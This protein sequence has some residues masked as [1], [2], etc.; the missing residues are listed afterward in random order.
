[1]SGS[2]PASTGP[3]GP[4]FEGQVGAHYL[5]TLL[6]GGEP[7]GL[8]GTQ[9]ERVAFQRA[10]GGFPLDDVI[11]HVPH[12]GSLQI[13]VK[14]S[15]AFSA[16]DAVFKRVVGQIVKAVAEPDFWNGRNELAIATSRS[17]RKIDGPYQDVLRWARQLGSATTFFDRLDR[18][19][20]ASDDM[21]SFVN[22]F[23][24]HLR[25]AGAAHNDETVWKILQRL[26]ILVF[27]YTTPGSVSE[28][29]SRERAARVLPTRK[30]SEA[31]KLWATLVDIALAAA[32]DGGDL[33]YATLVSQLHD[34]S[35]HLG[36]PPRFAHA[37][38]KIA[39]DAALAL[40]DMQNRVSGMTLARTERVTAVNA[41][42]DSGRYVEIRGDAGVGKSGVLR[43]FAEL[44]QA[45][46]RILV[47]SPGRTPRSGW[48]TLRA[49]LDFEGTAR[50]LLIDLTT[51]GGAV[52]IIDNLDSF[53]GGQRLTVNDLVRQAAEVPGLSVLVTARRNFGVA[54][55]TWLDSDAIRALHPSPVV[56]IDELSL[57]EVGEL[58]AAEPR[59]ATLL[60]D[61]HP[62]RDVVRN[63]YRLGRLA[64]S[65]LSDPTPTTELHLA[66][67]WWNSAD[68]TR[69]PLHRDRARVLRH[70]ARLALDGSFTYDVTDQPSAAVTALVASETLRDLGNDRVT[71]Q[72]DVLRQWAI[73]N[74]LNVDITS[75]AGLPLARP[76]PE[77]VAQ[78]VELAARFL[79]ER[80]KDDAGWLKLL[81]QMS[82][83]DIHQSWRRAVLLALVH[84]DVA[85]R[86]LDQECGR[87]LENDAALLRELVLTVMA[88]DVEPA[89]QLLIAMGVDPAQVPANF[90]VPTAA[91]WSHLVRLLL[92]LGAAVPAK[93][94]SEIVS[95]YSNFMLGTFGRTPITG[96]LLAWIYAWLVELENIRYDS[97]NSKTYVGKVSHLDVDGL[98]D[99]LRTSFCLFSNRV[100]DLA[101]TYL[102]RIRALD[103]DH[104]ATSA[105]MKFR[106]TLAQAAPRELG[107]LTAKKLIA[108]R[109]KRGRRRDR[110]FWGP[111]EH[112]DSEFLPPSPA[113]GP[114]FE[115]LTADPEQG[116]EL[117]RTL[118]AHAINYYTDG[119]EAG[120]D[121]FRLEFDG[122]EQFFPWT[123]TYVW[124]RGNNNFYAMSSGLM[125]LEAWAHRRIEAGH[126]ISAVLS[127]VLGPPGGCAAF[128]LVAV[129]I[130]MSR[131][132]ER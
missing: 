8:P 78:G 60:R 80:Q 69:D 13:Q 109:P 15:I 85:D 111:F 89:S 107:A 32:A 28:E 101:A 47:L 26:L 64:L 14:R 105:V 121:G 21:R 125:A 130:V 30:A 98:L 128:L 42:L 36:G 113:Q 118:V 73:G 92:R 58:S 57:T 53:D 19:G 1:M 77:I 2:S 11:V 103:Y 24:Q 55:P 27:D 106:G 79:L 131:V 52:L 88:I 120:A 99:R 3:A 20:I 46:G 82:G 123:Q 18:P 110:D 67:Q 96:N 132:I 34:R 86:L 66:E 9:I 39:E 56:I 108:R 81:A 33:D 35:F 23:R 44:F 100:P 129:D 61:T 5:L 71:F 40:A 59:L 102:K 51:D 70:L 41:A 124:A 25:D 90:F 65:N 97:G 119:K 115:L 104:G 7:R 83:A 6:A 122:E 62:A 112:L 22:T 126:D 4:W 84:S 91:S 50:D 38:A 68:G 72:H 45:E 127:D 75:L 93:A 117:I 87:L 48:P 74:F 17:S 31:P 95:L 114:F 54:E 10:E 43:H 63:L 12:D 116:L 94:L 16:G 37:R 49:L 29:L 76:A